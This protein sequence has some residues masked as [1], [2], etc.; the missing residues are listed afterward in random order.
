[1]NLYTRLPWTRISQVIA[2]T[3][4]LAGL[5]PHPGE[6]LRDELVQ[7]ALE[8][9]ADLLRERCD[10]FRVAGLYAPVQLQLVVEFAR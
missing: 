5:V 7:V 3:R 9:G 8:P 10:T 6:V 4:Y 1:M 2:R